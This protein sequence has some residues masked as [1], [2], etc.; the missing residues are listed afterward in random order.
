[1]S[2]LAAVFRLEDD[3][4]DVVPVALHSPDLLSGFRTQLQRDQADVVISTAYT[5]RK[6]KIMLL[7]RIIKRGLL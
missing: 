1:M 7:Q 3:G 5:I 2:D 6:T 4:V